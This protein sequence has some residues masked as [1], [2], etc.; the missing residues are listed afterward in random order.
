MRERLRFLG[1]VLWMKDDRLPKIV[2]SG[3][4][5]RDKR[6]ASRPRLWWVD[7]IIFFF[8]KEMGNS[9]RGREALNRLG[10]RRS[11]RNYVGLRQL[12]HEVSCC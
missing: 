4:P 7:V 3:Q 10:W 9:W 8:L 2:L 6:K 11:V 5:S 12:G 1:H